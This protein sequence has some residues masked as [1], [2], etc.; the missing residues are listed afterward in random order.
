MVFVDTTVKFASGFK[1]ANLVKPDDSPPTLQRTGKTRLSI[2]SL[3]WTHNDAF[4]IVLFNTGALAVLPRLASSFLKV[5][6][7]TVGNIGQNDL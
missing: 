2:A 3:E 6:N 1:T 4:V 5:Y 7:P